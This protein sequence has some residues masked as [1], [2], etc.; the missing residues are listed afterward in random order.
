MELN[1]KGKNIRYNNYDDMTGSN[2]EVKTL[3]TIFVF[4]ST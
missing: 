2:D 3:Q 1:K 4:K